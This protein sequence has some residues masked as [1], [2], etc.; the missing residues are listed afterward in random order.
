MPA[1]PG[2]PGKLSVKTER[3]KEQDRGFDPFKN[4][5]TTCTTSD[6]GILSILTLCS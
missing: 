4:Q 5:F 6:I 2:T 3:E 1:I